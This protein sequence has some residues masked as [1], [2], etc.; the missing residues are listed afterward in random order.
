MV[1]ILIV[2][3]L[4]LAWVVRPVVSHGDVLGYLI[5]REERL[6]LQ[7]AWVRDRSQNQLATIRRVRLLEGILPGETVYLLRLRSW[8]THSGLWFWRCVP[9]GAGLGKRVTAKRVKPAPRVVGSAGVALRDTS[10]RRR[11][12]RDVGG[13]R[14]AE[15]RRGVTIWNRNGSGSPRRVRNTLN[16][17]PNPGLAGYRR[18]LC[19]CG[20]FS[21]ELVRFGRDPFPAGGLPRRS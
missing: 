5:G 21:G 4:E 16:S 11:P 10:G 18:L 8:P 12:G 9:T 17:L 13:S 15:T 14:R 1:V 6:D 7:W 3:L 19:A 20:T 2:L